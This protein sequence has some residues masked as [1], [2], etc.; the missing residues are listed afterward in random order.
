MPAC[1]EVASILES[2]GHYLDSALLQ[3]ILHPFPNDFR[4]WRLVV[5]T[6]LPVAQ[7]H[8]EL[9]LLLWSRQEHLI[10]LFLRPQGLPYE[11]R[12]LLT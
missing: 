3:H 8:G 2:V 4:Y 1:Q 7:A 12:P 10:P 5:D 11:K 9:M 6:A